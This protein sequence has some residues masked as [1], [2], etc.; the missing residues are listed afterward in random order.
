MGIRSAAQDI[1]R[2]GR[3]ILDIMKRNEAIDL[4]WVKH[5]LNMGPER[6]KWTYMVDEISKMERPKKT[7][8]THEMIEAWNPLKAGNRKRDP[9]PSQRC[10]E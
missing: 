4:M 7:K 8:E 6:P 2:G 1:E 5:Y 10:R 3:K 9:P